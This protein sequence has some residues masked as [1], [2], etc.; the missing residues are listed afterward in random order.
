MQLSYLGLK[1]KKEIIMDATFIHSDLSN[2]KTDKPRE[3]RKQ[4]IIS[5]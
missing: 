4:V 1:I 3:N 5:R 2:T